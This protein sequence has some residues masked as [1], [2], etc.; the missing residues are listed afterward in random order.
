MKLAIATTT[1]RANVDSLLAAA[2]VPEFDVI[3]AGDDVVAKKPAPDIF[4][5][6]LDALG[7]PA[8]NAIALEDSINGL[9]SA[10]GAGL[11]CVVTPSAYGDA[12]PFPGA[13]AVLT[14]LGEEHA[15]ATTLAGRPPPRGIADLAWLATLAD[16]EVS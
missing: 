9:A 13:A 11:A 10:R 2:Q 15:P 4:L 6:A 12:G 3:A 8:S 14:D 16:S 1:T 7:L 5:H